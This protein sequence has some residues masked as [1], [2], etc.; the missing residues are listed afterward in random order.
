MHAKD[1]NQNVLN[2]HA[3][4]SLCQ[5]VPSMT[6]QL[7]DF[8]IMTV[9][10]SGG[11]ELCAFESLPP[12]WRVLDLAQVIGRMMD[13]CTCKFFLLFA[14][15]VMKS[16]VLL[17]DM[18][19]QTPPPYRVQHLRKVREGKAQI[20]DIICCYIRTHVALD[21]FEAGV[22]A[23]EVSCHY[24]H[25]LLAQVDSGKLPRDYRRPRKC[26]AF[27]PAWELRAAGYTLQELKK[28]KFPNGD[29]LRAGFTKEDLMDVMT[30]LECT[31]RDEKRDED[32]PDGLPLISLAAREWL[33]QGTKRKEMQENQK[34]REEVHNTRSHYESIG[35]KAAK[36]RKEAVKE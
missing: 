7:V 11:F 29:L 22:P 21:W 19:S 6:M 12:E 23:K 4:S 8:P 18:L 5:S 10:D 14:G 35:C 31:Q 33:M 17:R 1:L 13:E 16:W 3:S 30:S 25:W 26:T 34:K 24:Y 2:G 15:K 36:R 32:D 20:P 27:F 9:C 28:A